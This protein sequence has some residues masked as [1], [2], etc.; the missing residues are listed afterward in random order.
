M[1]KPQAL[2]KWSDACTVCECGPTV[3]RDGN[4][5]TLER[6]LRRCSD[7]TTVIEKASLNGDMVVEVRPVPNKPPEGKEPMVMPP[8]LLVVK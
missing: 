8:F 1:D 2:A 5:T 3:V 6:A 4:W 7:T